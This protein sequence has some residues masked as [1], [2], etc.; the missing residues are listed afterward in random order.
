MSTNAYLN[1]L[2]NE[3]VIKCSASLA[4][5]LIFRER[6][7]SVLDWISKGCGFEP[8]QHHY[9]VSLLSTRSTLEDPS[10]HN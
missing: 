1:L 9:V 7:G 5:D 4:C 6:S 2:L 10:R 3:K 8:H